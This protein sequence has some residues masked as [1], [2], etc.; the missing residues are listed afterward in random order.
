MSSETSSIN[1]K[2]ENSEKEREKKC[3]EKVVWCLETRN[4][5]WGAVCCKQCNDVND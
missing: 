3:I 5:R 1:L 2:Q 4:E